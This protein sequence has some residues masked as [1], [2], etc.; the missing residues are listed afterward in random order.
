MQKQTNDERPGMS[1]IDRY[2]PD[3]S[4]EEREAALERLQRLARVLVRIEE[5]LA[6]EWYEKW[7]RSNR[8]GAVKLK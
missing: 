6:R 3:A 2:M 7:I 4:A 1:F 5:R 8:D